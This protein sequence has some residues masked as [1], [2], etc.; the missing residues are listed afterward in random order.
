MPDKVRYLVFLPPSYDT[1]PERRYPVLYFLHDGYGTERTLARR[2]VISEL[3]ARM[4]DGR[5]P[6]FLVVAPFGRGTWFSDSHDGKVRYERFLVDRFRRDVESRYRVL[7]E[8]GA[9]GVTGISV[10]GYAAV[11]LGLKHPSLYGAVSSLSG[12]L[13][14]IGWDE[15]ERYGSRTKSMLTRVFGDSPRENSLLENDVWEIT[16]SG[17]SDPPAVHLRGGTQDIHGLGRVATQFGAWLA[18]HGVPTTVV[19]EPGEHRWS[20][21]KDALL[22][23]FEWH[24]RQ[25]AYDSKQ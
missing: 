19:M 12:P 14:P 24:A 8:K 5:L 6:E 3:A 15:L 22:H 25:F 18:E 20:Y 7:A 9:R 10:G 17:I 11:K 4:A 16:R 2:G 23:V 21:W 1:S 13:I